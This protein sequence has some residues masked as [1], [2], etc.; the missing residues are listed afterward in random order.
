MKIT[1][2]QKTNYH[3]H[4]NHHFEAHY[5]NQTINVSHLSGNVY[6]TIDG[7][8]NCTPYETHDHAHDAYLDSQPVRTV[9]LA[10]HN[11]WMSE[12]TPT[13][14]NNPE[15]YTRLTVGQLNSILEQWSYFVEQIDIPGSLN[16]DHKKCPLTATTQIRILNTVITAGTARYYL[17]LQLTT[18]ED[19]L[20]TVD[21]LTHDIKQA[22][23]ILDQLTEYTNAF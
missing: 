4:I 16:T 1:L 13:V 9:I 19:D 22:I 10:A 18:N 21:I 5:Q 7:S 6:I 2:N 14:S 17:K 12:T 15:P 11:A 3:T 20:H 23:R 8:P